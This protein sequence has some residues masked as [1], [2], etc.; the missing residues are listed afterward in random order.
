MVEGVPT[1]AEA[2]YVLTNPVVQWGVQE[3]QRHRLHPFL[4]AYLILRRQAAREGSLTDLRPRWEELEVFFRVEGGPPGKPYF[5]PFWHLA[6][7]AGQEWLNPNLAGSYAPSSLRTV[8]LSVVTTSG[9]LFSLKPRHWELARDAL[10]YSKRIP[11]IALCLFLYR[12]FGFISDAGEP[13]PEALVA[14]FRDDFGYG[15]DDDAEFHHLYD[16]ALPALTD[17]F[18]LYSPPQS[19]AA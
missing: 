12:D 3:L 14:L 11:A 6:R 19:A 16:V 4:P 18:I 1:P 13:A 8:P 17:W 9:S 7:D 2:T 15:G 5:R 10:T